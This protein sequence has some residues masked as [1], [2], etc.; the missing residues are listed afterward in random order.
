MPLYA[1]LWRHIAMYMHT[2]REVS[3][4]LG[5]CRASSNTEQVAVWQREVNLTKSCPRCMIMRASLYDGP[6]VKFA[7]L[8]IH[9]L[10][11]HTF[12]Q[13][14]VL[15][16]LYSLEVKHFYGDGDKLPRNLR[17]LFITKLSKPLRDL[18]DLE[19][20]EIRN[21]NTQIGQLPNSLRS[22][23]LFKIKYGLG[24]VPDG[25]QSLSIDYLPIGTIL[26]PGLTNMTMWG[27]K[28][29]PSRFRFPTNLTSIS[30]TRF[31]MPCSVLKELPD[32][33][34]SLSIQA[35]KQTSAR[36]LAIYPGNYRISH[37]RVNS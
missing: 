12:D 20:V 17:D 18:P 10:H 28:Y 27:D 5:I 24:K 36:Y 6:R 33:V 22:L 14:T 4:V 16:P 29:F 3:A 34:T 9:H 35:Y 31:N 13:S 8:R 7:H 30:I 23:T 21:V 15:P 1:V 26:P 11:M 25:L 19:R 37:S 32:T 2:N